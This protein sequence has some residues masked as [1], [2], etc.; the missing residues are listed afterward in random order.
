MWENKDGNLRTSKKVGVDFC[1][2]ESSVK[3]IM[4]WKYHVDEPTKGR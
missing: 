4:T 1:L 3:K 2:L